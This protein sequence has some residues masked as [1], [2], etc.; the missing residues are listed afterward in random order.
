MAR[1]RM[2]SRTLGT[3]SK[4]FARLR[5]EDPER[6]L[7]AQALYPLL[8][9]CTDD[10]GR[11][12]GDAFAVKHAVWPTAPESEDD[13]DHALDAMHAVGLIIRYVSG[14]L[15]CLQVVDFERHQQGLHKRTASR[16][17]EV[18]GK[19]PE[20][21]GN[22]GSREEKRTE[23]KGTKTPLTPLTGG[24]RVTRQ[25]RKHAEEIRRMRF[26]CPHDP[27]C[28]RHHDCIE[29]IAMELAERRATA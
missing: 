15:H 16:Y 5:T 2:I 13:F 7:F 9:A 26:G 12:D 29:A 18:S 21:P 17:P 20:S 22:S 23:E 10:F 1:G 19:F 8:V 11:M 25:D 28:E 27:R 4:K 3:Q 14:D 24:I 6:G